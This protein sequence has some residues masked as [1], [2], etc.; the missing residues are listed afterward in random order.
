LIV[1]GVGVFYLIKLVN[2]GSAG[3][4]LG[5][6]FEVLE[7]W[8]VEKRW[9]CFWGMVAGL[10]AFAASL[11]FL[12]TA[13]PCY[14]GDCTMDQENAALVGMA[15]VTFGVLILGFIPTVR[16]GRTAKM[17]RSS[18]PPIPLEPDRYEP[19]EHP[20]WGR[21][22]ATPPADAPQPPVDSGA[23]PGPTSHSSKG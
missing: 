6:P 9:Q 15:V 20:G 12:F 23:E 2:V 14:N 17:V 1:L 16:A 8:R 21:P 13:D 4:D 3:T 19:R 22:V 7:R 10:A 5:M 11:A 18:A